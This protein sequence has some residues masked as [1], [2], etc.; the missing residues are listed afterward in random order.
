[1]C[2]QDS[3]DP[4]DAAMEASAALGGLSRLLAGLRC[5]ADLPPQGLAS[6]VG[7]VHEKLEPA[8]DAL[9]RCSLRD[10]VPDEG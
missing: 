4:R 8:V 9:Q 5:D 1:M 3:D 7:L 6:L 2:N 10:K